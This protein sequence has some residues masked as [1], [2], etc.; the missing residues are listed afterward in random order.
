VNISSYI[1][2][3]FFFFF[4]WVLRK[5][6]VDRVYV[7]GTW[8]EIRPNKEGGRICGRKLCRR[9][10]KRCKSFERDNRACGDNGLVDRIVRECFNGL[11]NTILPA[12]P[13]WIV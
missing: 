8:S 9:D 10:G 13:T 3:V 1:S 6:V 2:R 5:F 7:M 4:F 12:R 11:D